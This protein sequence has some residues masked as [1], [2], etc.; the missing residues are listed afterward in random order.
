MSQRL[1]IPFEQLFTNLG[2]VGAGWKI[3][4]YATGTSTPLATY[5]DTSLTTPNTNPVVADSAGRLGPM[6]VSSSNLYKAVLLDENDVVIQTA[7]PVDSVTFSLNTFN[8]IP[9]AFWGT[10]SGSS[11]VYSLDSTVDISVVGY[12]GNQTFVLAFHT[13][14]GNNPTIDIDDLGALNL[15]KYTGSG[16]KTGL[17]AGD[18]QVQRYLAT[19][20]GTDIVI[21]NPQSGNNFPG[22]IKMSGS[23]TPNPGWLFCNGSAVSRTIY[24]GLFAAIG[25]TFGA[26]DGSTTFNIPDFRGYFPRGWADN[27]SIDPGRTFGSTQSDTFKAHTHQVFQRTDTPAGG[28][29]TIFTAVGTS[30][31]TY[32]G[33]TRSTGGTETR[34]VNLAIA[35]YIKY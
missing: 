2:A 32:T 23:S 28:P 8:P 35:F 30:T 18:V 11:V 15:K 5:S 12:Q 20:D 10:T 7:D 22:D 14:C 4:T 19:N 6:F 26:G 31:G 1:Y 24:D 27:G 29:A 13:P 21:L 16:T 9:T 25:T 17:V 33:D 34:P 3:A